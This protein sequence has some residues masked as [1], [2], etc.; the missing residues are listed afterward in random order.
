MERSGS[1]SDTHGLI[2]VHSSS[3]NYIQTLLPPEVLL[4]IVVFLP[5]HDK[6]SLRGTCRRLQ[7]AV[8][9][10]AAWPT[11]SFHYCR[12]ADKRVLDTVI[13]L[14]LS[15][16]QG[17][18]K[19][20]IT[21]QRNTPRFPL[22]HFM[23]RITALSC[24]HHL[25]LLGFDQFSTDLRKIAGAVCR[26]RRL[27]H[28]ILDAFHCGIQSK[29][30]TWWFPNGRS[31]ISFEMRAAKVVPLFVRTALGRW[32]DTNF[33]PCIFKLS[34]KS[35]VTLNKHLFHAF[36]PLSQFQP[37]PSDDCARFNLIQSQGPLGI[38]SS[39]PFLELIINSNSFSL[40]IVCFKEYTL[41]LTLS[42][43]Q[44]ATSVPKSH[45]TPVEQLLV[46]TPF[47][48]IASGLVHLRLDGCPDVG[49]ENLEEIATC[50]P[51]LESL[52][53]DSCN[54]ALHPVNGLVRVSECCLRLAGLNV[55]AIHDVGDSKALWTVLCKFRKLSYLAVEYC[56]LPV[57]FQSQD[58]RIGAL[59]SLQIGSMFKSGQIPA[60]NCIKCRSVSDTYLQTLARLVPS[61]QKLLRMSLPS[62][63]FGRGLQELLT[64]MPQLKCIYLEKCCPGC[65]SLPIKC[66]FYQK[67]EKFHLEAW[68]YVIN[69]EFIEALGA[70]KLLSHFYIKVKSISSDAVCKLI[71]LP[72]LVSCHI[73]CKSRAYNKTNIYK[74]AR[75]L[76]IS[77]FSYNSELS[78]LQPEFES[79][80]DN[81]FK[82]LF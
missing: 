80:L 52:S 14:C 76:G 1:I 25:S 38:P 50:C 5:P 54:K 6:L 58:Q 13:D 61:S 41:L 21:L 45:L 72:R 77:D 27:T 23:N 43:P 20:E 63:T 26:F 47:L 60:I 81:D 3:D 22:V 75:S 78:L 11:L 34:S 24:V 42:F 79:N 31:L 17:P 12:P 39:R 16:S 65:L 28:L 36:L 74:A 29:P 51:L 8:S 68:S 48:S 2:L 55:S 57:E 53:I 67:L 37:L 15:S 40:P 73:I 69:P 70:Q 9:D 71:Q 30:S 35:I 62:S 33:Y 4:L 59:V 49:S 46:E 32:C 18:S 10:P 64:T 19:L 82:P 56:S 7:A 66:Q 44:S